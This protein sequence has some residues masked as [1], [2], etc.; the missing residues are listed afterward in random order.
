MRGRAAGMNNALNKGRRVRRVRRLEA[1]GGMFVRRAGARIQ[2]TRQREVGEKTHGVRPRPS[3]H[4][5]IALAG[6]SPLTDGL[7]SRQGG[8]AGPKK[9]ICGVFQANESADIQ[10][11]YEHSSAEPEE[12]ILG[13]NLGR[14]LRRQTLKAPR[15]VIRSKRRALARGR[16]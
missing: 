9:R 3:K 15:L 6:L 8:K 4:A 2:Q 11:P 7:E 1:K 5:K 14:L 16:M 13:T 10:G 12:S